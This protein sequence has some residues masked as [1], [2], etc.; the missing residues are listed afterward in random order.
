MKR[1]PLR[2]RRNRNILCP[3]AFRLHSYNGVADL[4]YL[5]YRAT[6]LWWD[7]APLSCS[8]LKLPNVFYAPRAGWDA[9]LRG[10]RIC[11]LAALG[12]PVLRASL[13]TVYAY[14]L[15]MGHGDFYEQDSHDNKSMNEHQTYEFRAVLQSFAF[16]ILVQRGTRFVS[17]KLLRFVPIRIS[18]VSDTWTS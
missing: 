6:F 15:N 10:W 2:L 7:R 9:L 4:S 3:T 1:I 17:Q 14:R 5:P 18:L 11:F 13:V 8:S 16:Y 12:W